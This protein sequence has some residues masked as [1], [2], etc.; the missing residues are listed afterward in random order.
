MKVCYHCLRTEVADNR[1]D[2]HGSRDYVGHSRHVVRGEDE[3]D[4]LSQI[5]SSH[6]PALWPRPYTRTTMGR[7][8]SGP[9][10]STFIDNGGGVFG[11]G[12]RW[13]G[14][15]IQ[16]R[17]CVLSLHFLV[18]YDLLRRRE[19]IEQRNAY[20]QSA[21]GSKWWQ[22]RAGPGVEGEWIIMKKDWREY[23]A[24]QRDLA[25]GAVEG[26]VQLP[27]DPP[28]DEDG[29]GP[30]ELPSFNAPFSC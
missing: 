2:I 8:T 4:A 10:S 15:G 18:A 28:E 6:S 7:F 26:P 12:F 24:N 16:D 13:R 5:S 21:G 11:Q 22:V 27:V 20:G 17:R 29:N 14:D 9:N 1:I 30:C 19:G 23:Q 3:A 25:A